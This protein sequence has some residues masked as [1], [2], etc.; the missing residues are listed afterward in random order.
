METY[1]I[2]NGPSRTLHP[3]GVFQSVIVDRW[4]YEGTNNA[5]SE[6]IQKE[7]F[8]FETSEKMEDGKPY[9]VAKF[10]RIPAKS[11]NDASNL[12]KFAKAYD[13][14]TDEGFTPESM[15]GKKFWIQVDHSECGNYDNVGDKP[16]KMSSPVDIEPNPDFVRKNDR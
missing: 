8:V 14:L 1:A 13:G 9:H 10:V 6:P 4:Q 16:V 3:E 11:F 5:T 12:Y 2:D 15:V 7:V